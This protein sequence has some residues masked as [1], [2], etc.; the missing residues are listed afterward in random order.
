MLVY[1]LTPKTL[2]FMGRPIPPSGGSRDY[3]ELDNGGFIPTRDLQLEKDKVLAFGKLP[4]WWTLEQEVK[5][6]PVPEA[7][8]VEEPP[9]VEA[10]ATEEFK[11]SVKEGKRR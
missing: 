5:A 6:M 9:A 1:N 4:Y 11:P 2:L 3:P 10:Q 8:K 7:P